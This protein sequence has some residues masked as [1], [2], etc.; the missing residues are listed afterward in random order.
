MFRIAAI[1]IAL[2]LS[3]GTARAGDASLIAER[4]GFLLG[5]GYRC[6]VSE[7]QLLPAAQLIHSLIEAAAT[8]SDA[9]D[10]AEESFAERF[11]TAAF[12]EKLGEPAAACGSVRSELTRLVAYNAAPPAATKD[13]V[14]TTSAHAPAVASNKPEARQK[15]ATNTRPALAQERRL[16]GKLASR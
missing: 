16:P 9:R 5:H 2:M 11:L 13:V 1:A 15:K 3:I 7:V 14:A 6:H 8:D 12:A 4:G 10:V